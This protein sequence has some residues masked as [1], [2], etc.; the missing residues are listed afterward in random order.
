VSGPAQRQAPQPASPAF[1]RR[2]QLARRRARRT[3]A[4]VALSLRLTLASRILVW[5]AGLGALALFGKNGAYI[6]V[7]D[8]AHLS[9]PFHSGLANELIA[10]AARWDS[11]W[12]L[13]IAHLGYYSH[14]STAFFP[15]YPLLIHL[16]AALFGSAILC[17]ALIS[18]G[19]M[20]VGL[21]LLYRLVALDLGERE[22]RMTVALLALFPSSFFLSAVYTESLFLAL[23]VGAIYCARLDRWAWAGLLGALAAASRSTGV[24]IAIPLALIYLYGPREHARARIVGSWSEPRHRPGRSL[25]WLGLVP[26]GTLAYLA[27]LAISHIDP[28][29]PFRAENLYWQRQFAGLFGAVRDAVEALPGDVRGVWTGNSYPWGRQDPLTIADHCLIDFGFLA[30]ALVGLAACWRRVPFAYLAYTLALLAEALSYP[31]QT[32]ALISFPRYLLVMFPIFIG[33]AALLAPRRKLA[34]GVLALSALG[35]ACL[36]GL[37]SMWEWVA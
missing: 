8:P 31:V 32:D 15:L 24:L 16:C 27:Y 26:L 33:W 10:P 6:A 28:L 4:A 21:A 22:A 12:Y 35:L 19:A 5:V 18:L 34:I 11:V 14:Q 30:F 2:G 36:S 13:S 20:G 29:T 37:W 3:D 25:L 1:P 7:F 9:E 23:S 17:G